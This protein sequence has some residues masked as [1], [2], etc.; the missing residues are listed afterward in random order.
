MK[1]KIFTA[2]CLLFVV[3]LNANAFGLG[4]ITVVSSLNDPFEASIELTGAIDFDETQIVV[5]LGNDAE[6]KQM[7]VI[8]E[9]VLLQLVFQPSLKAN[10]PVIIVRSQKP[11]REPVLNFVLNVQSPKAQMMKEYTVF[12]NPSK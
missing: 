7:G 8:R 5:R 11:I 6:F 10:P 3:N 2:L 12:L 4:K 1:I 9:S